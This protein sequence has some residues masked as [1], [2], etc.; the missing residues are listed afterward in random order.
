[1]TLKGEISSC[2]RVVIQ[3]CVEACVTDCQKLEILENGTF[4]G[5]AT[6]VDAEIAGELTGTLRVENKLVVRSTARIVGTV[7]YGSLIVDE[8][9]VLRATFQDI[10]PAERTDQPADA[11][12]SG[13]PS[14]VAA[15]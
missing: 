4:K 11:F 6:V 3:G 10:T 8:G 2:E 1:M 14:D 15:E 5:S 13:A 12:A 9:C 7:Y